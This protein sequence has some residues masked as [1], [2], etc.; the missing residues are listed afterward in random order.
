MKGKVKNRIKRSYMRLYGLL[1]PIRPVVL[2]SSFCGNQYSDNPRAISE[3]LHELYPDIAIQWALHDRG[4][5]MDLVPDYVSIIKAR[6]TEFLENLA[7]AKIFVTNEANESDVYKKKC[8]YFIQTWHGDRAP[9]KVIYDAWPDGKRPIPVIDNEV[10]DLCIA[11][12]DL[13]ESV[14]RSAFKYQGEVLKIGMPRNDCLVNTDKEAEQIIRSRLHISANSKILLFAPTFRDTNAGVQNVDVDL[15]SV[16][17]LL[18]AGGENW[19]CLIRAH[20][21]SA[22]LKFECDGKRT[23]NVSKYPDMADLLQIADMLI[24]D[25][26][27]CAGDFVIKQKPVILAMFDREDYVRNCRGFRF[28]IEEA[29]F[30]VVHDQAELERLLMT[31]TAEDYRENCRKIIENLH[32]I[33]TGKASEEISKRIAAFYYDWGNNGDI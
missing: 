12:S 23:I 16:L 15:D 19:I 20:I 29:G 30:L 22:G 33:E 25:Y 32:I 14:Y 5:Q 11:G 24:T 9:K 1:H 13:G 7:C 4:Q 2:F 27:S 8:Q 10:T 6:G 17:R 28:D 26:S 3:K 21:A 31:M 18:S